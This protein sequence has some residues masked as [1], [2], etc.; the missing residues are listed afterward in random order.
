MY[1][2]IFRN[3]VLSFKKITNSVIVFHIT[4][5]RNYKDWKSSISGDIKL[6]WSYFRKYSSIVIPLGNDI[7]L[8]VF[9]IDTRQTVKHDVLLNMDENQ[10]RIYFSGCY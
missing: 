8:E 7:N 4:N 3:K 6:D 1:I 2:K 5:I 10:N 9:Y